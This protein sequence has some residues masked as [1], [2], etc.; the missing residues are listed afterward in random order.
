[1]GSAASHVCRAGAIEKTFDELLAAHPGFVWPHLDFV[2]WANLPGRRDQKEVASRIRK[3]IAVCPGAVEAYEYVRL[4]DDP[5]LISTAATNLRRSLE[6]RN[7]LLDA[8]SWINLWSLE[9]RAGGDPALFGQRIRAD[10]KRLESLPFQPRLELMWMY[11]QASDLLKDPGIVSGFEAKVAREAPQSLLMLSLTQQR[12][13]RENPPPL[14]DAT[15]EQR[16]AYEAK[17]GA[18]RREWAERWPGNCTVAQ[19]E[20]RQFPLRLRQ[21]AN[22]VLTEREL[23]VA[24]QMQRCVAESPDS[25][26]SVPPLETMLAELYVKARTRLD[27]VPRLLDAGLRAMDRQEKYRVSRD[28]MPAELT[29]RA[30]PDLATMA[31]ERTQQIRAGYFIATGRTAE[32]RALV[33]QQLATVDSAKPP[34]DAPA[35]DKGQFR[36]RRSEWVRLLAEVEEKDN[37][38]QEALDLYRSMLEGN[39]REIL[40]RADSPL[41]APAR[42]LY[43]ANG[44]TEEKWLE[45]ATSGKAAAQTTVRAPVAFSQMLPD[46]SAEDLGG[47]TWRLRD[48]KG[49]ATIINFWATWCGPC[50]GELP[51]IQKLHER[52]KDRKDAQV[53][54]ISVDDTPALAAAYAKEKKYTFAVIHAPALADKLFPYAGLPTTFLVNGKG[55]RT[56]L[57]GF[58]SD[59]E[60][61]RR[62]LADLEEAARV[63]E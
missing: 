51:D 1:M 41:V 24:D 34:V 31:Q 36:W 33:Q 39:P 46:F 23:A 54:T 56:S 58:G 25:G 9:S 44:G 4:I 62:V 57:Y 5:E 26:M 17:R 37:H 21:E 45:W 13:E 3:F 29:Q 12:W 11:R 28:L 18:A 53:L 47:R 32:A 42:K 20:W 60:G 38:V 35:P 27:Q 48:L 40:A 22:L 16:K 7:T 49:K 2:E 61:L 8:S 19:E 14:R 6:M 30:G 59:E 43:L 15:P 63:R 50:R 10:L 52:L 55:Q